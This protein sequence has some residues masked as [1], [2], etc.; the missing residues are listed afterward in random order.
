MAAHAAA[1]VDALLVDP[2][3]AGAA[4]VLGHPRRARPA[5]VMCGVLPLALASRDTAPFGMGIP[6]MAGGLGRLRNALLGAVAG[7]ILRGAGELADTLYRDLHGTAMPGPILDWMRRADAIAQFT[8]PE[9]EYPRSDAPANLHFVGPVSASGSSAPL[10]A[11]WAELDGTRPVVHVSQGTIANKDLGQL[12]GPTLQALANDD[13]LVVVSTGGRPLDALPPLP[14]NARAAEYL[15]YDAL[16]PKTAVFVTN[17]GYGG[18]QYALR[19]GVPIVAS[20]GHE[21]KP[22]VG[23]RIAWS[24]VGRR[25]TAVAPTPAQLRQAIRAVLHD[26]RYRLAATAMAERMA[27]SGGLPALARIVD[28][29]VAQRTTAAA[30]E[31]PLQL[32]RAM[33]H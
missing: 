14:A 16:L 25:L 18:V 15:P 6:P 23:A 19:Y 12:V 4:F 20:G 5:V 11:W 9:F 1:P 21:D 8:V 7:R 30:R 33:A 17:G 31:R 10:P 29:A 32:L 28:D 26:P 22:E 3:F 27:R 13:V 2:A 24:G